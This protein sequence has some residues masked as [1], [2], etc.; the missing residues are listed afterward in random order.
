MEAI[1]PIIVI[2]IFVAIALFVSIFIIDEGV[3]R[4]MRKARSDERAELAE[5]EQWED[6]ESAD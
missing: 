6:N 2:A 5:M 1:G 4:G 3:R